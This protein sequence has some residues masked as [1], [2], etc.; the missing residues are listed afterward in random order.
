MY[1]VVNEPVAFIQSGGQ[2]AASPLS[3]QVSVNVIS[4]LSGSALSE[5]IVGV[6]SESVMRILRF[7]DAT[8][9]RRIRS[10]VTL[11]KSDDASHHR[12]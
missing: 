12:C 8:W 7:V 5:I 10:L 1:E 9:A 3:R 2:S 6:F 11:T 4:D